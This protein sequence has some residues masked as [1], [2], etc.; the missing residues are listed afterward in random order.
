MIDTV[1]AAV[2]AVAGKRANVRMEGAKA[3][4]V[5]DATGLD[6]ADRHALEEQVKAAA[7]QP[8][9]EDVRIVLTAE[10]LERRIIAVASGKVGWASRPCRPIWRSRS[11]AWGARPDWSMPISMASQPRLMAAEGVKPVA[12]DGKLQPVPTPY[13]VPLLSMGQL[14]EPDKAIA[15]AGRWRR[16]RS[17]S[18]STAIGA[19]PTPRSSTCRPAPA[20]CS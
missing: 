5:L 17:A 6:G 4:V 11:L 3:G 20:T 16:V 15:G 14:V 13:G 7:M 2:A 8:G 9:V 1:K 18:W 19:R 10:K 12:Q